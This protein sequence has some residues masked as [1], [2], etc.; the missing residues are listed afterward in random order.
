M[1]EIGGVEVHNVF[2]LE[3]IGAHSH[4]RGLGLN[5]SLAPLDVAD[6]MVGQH[7]ARKA[8][9][10][11]VKMIKQGHIAGRALLITGEPGTG[12][13]AI[14]MGISKQITAD[15]PF[16]SISASEVYSMDVSK[17]EALMQAFRKAIGIR[18]KEETEVDFC[19]LSEIIIFQVLEGEVVQIEIDRPASGIGSKIG[20]LTLKTTDMEAIFDIGN[21]MVESIIKERISV[22]DIIQIDKGS[23]WFSNDVPKFAD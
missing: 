6:G 13:T 18:I 9:G 7:S 21:K 17:T 14:A 15:T 20:K 12:K 8:A 3:R 22:G 11:I 16:V 19:N 1:I 4:I 5:E 23:G 10:I 2:K